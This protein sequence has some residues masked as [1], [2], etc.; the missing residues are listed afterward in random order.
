MILA[1]LSLASIFVILRCLARCIKSQNKYSSKSNP[2]L[3][4][5][6]L[7]HGPNLLVK[8]TQFKHEFNTLTFSSGPSM[9]KLTFEVGGHVTC[10]WTGHL[11]YKMSSPL[12][13]F[14]S[15]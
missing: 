7:G 8:L 15:S 2:T 5:K 11:S 10:E 14:L 12:H 13:P 9:T 1:L 6:L 3:F 4:L